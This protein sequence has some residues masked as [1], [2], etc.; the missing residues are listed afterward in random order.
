MKS[1]RAPRARDE[2]RCEPNSTSSSALDA[3]LRVASLAGK[4]LI[5]HKGAASVDAT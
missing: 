5:A 3:A 1:G 4:Q 2:S